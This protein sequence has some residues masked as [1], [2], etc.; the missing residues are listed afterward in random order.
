MGERI[1]FFTD[2]PAEACAALE[3]QVLPRR[4]FGRPEGLEISPAPPGAGIG[5]GTRRVSASVRLDLPGLWRALIR[6]GTKKTGPTVALLVPRGGSPADAGPKLVAAGVTVGEM[7]AGDDEYQCEMPL[8][9]APRTVVDFAIAA[10]TAVAGPSPT[11]EW[12]WA[13]RDKGLV[14]R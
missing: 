3:E 2:D 13:V 8:N 14:P 9:A 7:A 4:R 6:P 11:G 10:L 12:M 1:G 5:P